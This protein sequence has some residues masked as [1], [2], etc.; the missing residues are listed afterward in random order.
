[1]PAPAPYGALA[2]WFTGKN[3][4]FYR[5]E[6]VPSRA[7]MIISSLPLSSTTAAYF[8]LQFWENVRE[9]NIHFLNN[10]NSKNEKKFWVKKNEKLNYY[11]TG[12]VWKLQIKTTSF[13]CQKQ[14][15]SRKI[16][17]SAYNSQAISEKNFLHFYLLPK[18]TKHKNKVYQ[19]FCISSTS[20]FSVTSDL[21]NSAKPNLK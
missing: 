21:V 18:E 2:L 1:M 15:Y 20:Q 3:M 13:H 4:Q 7:S 10:T 8:Y 11:K 16:R 6:Q 12:Y 9:K 19:S 17:N 5:L 14:T